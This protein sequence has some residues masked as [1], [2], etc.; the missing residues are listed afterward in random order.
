MT[1]TFTATPHGETELASKRSIPFRKQ[2]DTFRLRREAEAMN[3]VRS[4]T[5]IPVP[6]IL[7]V[8]FGVNDHEPGWML[9]ER[10]PGRQLDEAW[11]T[12]E[13]T[14]RAQT[15]SELRS[16]LGRLHRL[17][18]RNRGLENGGFLACVVGIQEGLVWFSVSTIVDWHCEA[19]YEGVS[20][21]N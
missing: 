7:D 12:M 19:N 18:H 4:H 6:S 14:A 20:V 15:I 2:A 1:T 17:R 10:V 16:H 11:P 5:S 3:Y 9:M 21:R 8:Y 13:E